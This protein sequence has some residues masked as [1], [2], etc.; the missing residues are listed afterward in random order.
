[1]PYFPTS[2][3][4]SAAVLQ[5]PRTVTRECWLVVVCVPPK[6]SHGRSYLV[7][8]GWYLL[9]AASPY[10]AQMGFTR[11][12]LYTCEFVLSVCL[13]LLTCLL[14]YSI[15]LLRCLFPGGLRLSPGSSDGREEGRD[16]LSDVNGCNDVET[17]HCFTHATDA[18]VQH[19]TAAVLLQAFLVVSGVF[20]TCE[21]CCT[22]DS[23]ECVARVLLS[24]IVARV[25]LTF[26]VVALNQRSDLTAFLCI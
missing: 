8:C 19:L 16:V 25:F 6:S 10:I 7:C 26:F 5:L 17:Q 12:V 15:K 4:V 24:Q 3:E 14:H 13:V 20:L 2:P 22:S 9:C 1:M 23:R 21:N 18:C 11:S